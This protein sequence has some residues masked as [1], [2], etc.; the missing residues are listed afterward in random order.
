VRGYLNCS[1]HNEAQG[2]HEY[3][4]KKNSLKI[5]ILAAIVIKSEPFFFGCDFG[6]NTFGR[7]KHFLQFPIQ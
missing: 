1:S 4:M 2:T 6:N 5:T 3:A 7:P